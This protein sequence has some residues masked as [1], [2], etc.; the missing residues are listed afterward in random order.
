MFGSHSEGLGEETVVTRFSPH[1]VLGPQT[2]SHWN[3]I[4]VSLRVLRVEKGFGGHP[5]YPLVSHW[6]PGW[7]EGLSQGHGAGRGGA[8]IRAPV[9]G[10]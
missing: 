9:L 2:R 4:L 5:V 8:G 1:E 7:G 6:D 3:L 10:S